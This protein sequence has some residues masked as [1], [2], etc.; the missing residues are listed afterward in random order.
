MKQLMLALACFLLLLITDK[1]TAEA[2]DEDTIVIS[3]YLDIYRTE[4]PKKLYTNALE[5]GM[6]PVCADEIEQYNDVKDEISRTP[7]LYAISEQVE[8][9]PQCFKKEF[10]VALDA[11]RSK[12][13]NDSWGTKSGVIAI[14]LSKPEIP[15]LPSSEKLIRIE[16]KR[17]TVDSLLN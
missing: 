3:G 10:I 2:Q 7:A 15:L 5:P 12:I 9:Y 6:L 1:V 13:K 17:N 8:K 11:Y 16:D 4:L 14:L